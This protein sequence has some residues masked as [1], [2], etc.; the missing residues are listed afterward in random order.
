LACEVTLNSYQQDKWMSEPIKTIGVVG[1]GTI[2]VNAHIPVLRAMP[3]VQVAWVADADRARVDAVARANGIAG[4]HV[5]PGAMDLPPC[6]IVL[7]AIP[8]HVRRFYFDRFALSPSAVLAEKPFALDASEHKR[9]LSQFEPWR[10][11]CGYQRRHYGASLLLRRLVDVQPFGP[12]VAIHMF[13]GGR[14]TRAG[15]DSYIDKAVADGG[16]LIK[17]LGCHSLDLALWLTGATGFRVLERHVAW[18]GETDRHAT[19]EIALSGRAGGQTDCRLHWGTSWL[20]AQSNVVELEF[21]TARVRAGTGPVDHV[22]VLTRA[23]ERISSMPVG[24]T[25]GAVTI[26]QAFYLEWRDFLSGIG[27]KRAAGI[28]AQSCLAVAELMDELLHR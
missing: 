21:A 1:A 28:S 26:N 24:Q 7:L 15:G 6:D 23:G 4:V 27:E 18:D 17:N 10:A 3:G 9:L 20:E 22:E 2:A 12:L 8:L 11:G 5:A 13:E 16:G 19:A 25:G 14:T